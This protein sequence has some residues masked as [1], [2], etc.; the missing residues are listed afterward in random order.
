MG[1]SPGDTFG[2]YTIE[3]VLGSGGMG[4]VL[5]AFDTVLERKIALKIIRP[6]KASRE[7]AVARFLREAKLAAKLTHPNTI[8]IYDLGEVEGTPFIAM[9]HIDGKALTT[10][11]GNTSV[12]LERKL[13]WILDIARGLAA[14]HDHGL[15]H[16]DMKPANVMVSKDDAVKVVDFGL[17]KRFATSPGFRKTFRTD[18]GF[19]VGTPA[20]MAPEQLGGAEV[21]GRADEFSWGLTS[22]A[23]LWGENPR[24][25]DPSPFGRFPLLHDRLRE[26]PRSV[27]L[28]IGRALELDRGARFASMKI[29]VTELDA[30]IRAFSEASEPSEV[31]T[32][33]RPAERRTTGR[34]GRASMEPP[35]PAPP[36]DRE[37]W[38]FDRRADACPV[39]PIRAAA[40]SG[41]GKRIVAFGDAGMAI[42]RGQEGW[43]RSVTPAFIHAVH[44]VSYEGDGS[45]IVGGAQSLAARIFPD[46]SAEKW[47][48]R[49]AGIETFRGM[50]IS[51]RGVA[52]FA[53]GDVVV[54]C[55]TDPREWS[56]AHAEL[57]GVTTLDSGT[58]VACGSSGTLV[59]IAGE[60]VVTLAKVTHSR[61][62]ALT[63]FG[64]GALAVGED[65]VAVHIDAS[66]AVTVD[67]VRTTSSLAAVTVSDDQTA[68]AA[69]VLGRIV[70]RDATGTWKRVSRDFDCEPHAI[71]IWA[72]GDRVRVVAADGSIIMGWRRSELAPA[73]Q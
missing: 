15:V 6:D 50:T 22:Y 58:V 36:H 64:G 2:R 70:R 55:G 53:G 9:E 28:V 38:R 3:G 33:E 39:A 7:E 32:M 10:Y 12:P 34:L 20:F 19:V 8:R 40:F 46:G 51:A 48:T 1:T 44:C 29:L 63:P 13:R 61:L 69:S 54:R 18:A 35:P 43:S 26:F 21:D 49:S 25:R 68:W 72:K 47:P 4:Q 31:E 27:S 30:A 41:D 60:L 24:G 5:L 23:L 73:P 16:R 57:M 14:A 71:A 42:H 59:A 17:A 62:Q 56:V 65:G 45:I 11:C 37:S 52:T 67:D 66:L